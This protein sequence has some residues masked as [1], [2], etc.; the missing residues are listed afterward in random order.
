[1]SDP[2]TGGIGTE[3]T[4]AAIIQTLI[5][6]EYI[7][8]EKKALR[9]TQ[10]GI[11]LIQKLPLEQIKSAELTAKW[12]QR[13]GDIARGTENAETFQKDFEAALTEWVKIIKT[14]VARTNQ[15]YANMLDG[16]KCPLCSKTVHSTENGFE[17][18]AHKDGC[19][20]SIGTICGKK[21]TEAQV[22]KLLTDGS[23]ALIKGF[24]KKDGSKFN[25]KLKI[26]N[27]KM[28]F[29]YE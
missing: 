12:E 19:K 24:K 3:A 22:R 20:F 13:L 26:E 28:A 16:V 21:I 23:T 27:G 11:D 25:A 5:D 8:R 7:V 9:A 17:C 1:M 10:K 2:K 6:R 18:A 15:S 14:Q 4:R 29:E